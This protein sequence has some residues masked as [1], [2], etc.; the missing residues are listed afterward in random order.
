MYGQASL[1]HAD[2]A[3]PSALAPAA[4]TRVGRWDIT[5]DQ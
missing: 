3:E 2:A 5:T 1:A 4:D